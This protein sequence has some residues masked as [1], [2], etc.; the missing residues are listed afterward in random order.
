MKD[1][2]EQQ[3]FPLGSSCSILNS[4]L[5]TQLLTL[6]PVEFSRVIQNN[7]MKFCDYLTL[8]PLQLVTVDIYSKVRS[9]H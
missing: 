9:V 7:K 1:N 3:S 4:R 6:C 2:C 8:F 5:E